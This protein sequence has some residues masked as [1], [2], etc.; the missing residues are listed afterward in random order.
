MSLA[1]FVTLLLVPPPLDERSEILAAV[2]VLTDGAAQGDYAAFSSMLEPDGATV[3]ADLRGDRPVVTVLSNRQVLEANRNVK[4]VA[5]RDSRFGVPTVL[6][7]ASIAQ[8]WVPFRTEIG[9]KLSHCGIDNF[10]LAKRHGQW[11]IT[12]MSYTVEPPANC[13][14]IE[15]PEVSQ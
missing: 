4:P 9:G 5:D 8:V 10:S 6:I 2:R 1:A 14:D 7:R 13:E 15:V 3:L 12:N 11:M